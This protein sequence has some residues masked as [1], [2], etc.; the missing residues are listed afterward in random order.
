M[1]KEICDTGNLYTARQQSTGSRTS[2]AVSEIKPTMI[3]DYA[4][5]V[6]DLP[7]RL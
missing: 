1:D 5:R 3:A 6:P 7:A 4:D 2:N